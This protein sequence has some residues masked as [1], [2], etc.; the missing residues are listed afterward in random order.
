MYHAELRWFPPP[1]QIWNFREYPDPMRPDSV[2]RGTRRFR[3]EGDHRQLTPQY[4]NLMLVEMRGQLLAQFADLPARDAIATAPLGINS[5]LYVDVLARN[6][7]AYRIIK[8]ANLSAFGQHFHLAFSGAPF[9][10]NQLMFRVN[11]IDIRNRL[12][13]VLNA[14]RKEL[15]RSVRIIA[16]WAMYHRATMVNGVA[17]H[18]DFTGIVYALG[19]AHGNAVRVDT[20]RLPGFLE[21]DQ[22]DFP[23]RLPVFF[24]GRPD[25]C[26]V[27]KPRAPKHLSTEC[28]AG[29][30]RC[31]G[32]HPPRQCFYRH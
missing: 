3:F 5:S 12:V 13:P 19:E 4:L 28:Q 21:F 32:R 6:A 18:N 22:L 9:P 8:D 2:G 11:N 30:C 26:R 25:D 20:A 1:R 29:S 23:R 7:E 16:F 15:A 31:G 10:P 14:I 24:E 17:T 27:C